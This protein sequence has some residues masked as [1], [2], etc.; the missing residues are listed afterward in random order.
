MPLVEP[1]FDHPEN[2]NA[3][4]FW[5]LAGTLIPYDT[6]TGRP[7][8]LPGW[9]DFLPEIARHFRLVVTTGDGTASAREALTNF[10]I[11]PHMEAVFGDLIYPVG[12]PYGEILRQLKG[13][14]DRSLAVGDR[15]R[16]DIPSDTDQL[17]TILINQGGDIV[18]AGMVSFMTH[19]LRKQSEIFP[20]AFRLLTAAAAVEPDSLG[21]SYGGEITEAWRRNDGFDYRLMV[22]RHSALKGD[23]LVIVI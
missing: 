1:P 13:Q 15:L 20:E 19:I 2:R 12:K 10:E 8:P 22:Y 17:V 21:S 9:E 16:A 4:M 6:V 23:R 5:D 7:L 11:L 3:V 14:A 18:N